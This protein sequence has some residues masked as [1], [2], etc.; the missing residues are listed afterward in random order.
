MK[1]G[2]T[3]ICADKDRQFISKTEVSRRLGK[4]VRTIEAWMSA[5][6]IPYLKIG[7]SVMFSWEAVT[8]QLREN[9]SIN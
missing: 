6:Y 8:A 5:G 4:S 7:R 9:H 3:N 1:R 2:L